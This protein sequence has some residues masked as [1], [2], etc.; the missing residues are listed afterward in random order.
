M[1]TVNCGRVYVRASARLAR[2][3]SRYVNPRRSRIW[4]R[5]SPGSMAVG[6]VTYH[7]VN[8]SEQLYLRKTVE[9]LYLMSAHE[10]AEDNAFLLPSAKPGGDC[11]VNLVF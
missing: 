7:D 5:R 10:M 8:T 11:T 9:F 6:K 4:R 1:C 2:W 3:T